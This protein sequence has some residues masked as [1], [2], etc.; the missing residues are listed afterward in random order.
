MI[1][2][3]QFFLWNIYSVIFGYLRPSSENVQRGSSGLRN[4]FEK[5][6]EIFVNGRKSSENRQKRRH[7]YVYI[8]NRILHARL[9]IRILSFRV[10]LAISLASLTSV[11]YQVEHEKI[12]FISARGHV[13]SSIS[14]FPLALVLTFIAL[15]T[16][17]LRRNQSLNQSN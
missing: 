9:W 1:R 17:D 15:A 13:V 6:S 5:T 3:H 10:Q 16:K 11:R 2:H 12:K 4:N 8:I 7:L 14:W